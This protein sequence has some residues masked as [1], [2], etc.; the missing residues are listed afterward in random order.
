MVELSLL[1][2]ISLKFQP[3]DRI[4]Y[5]IRRKQLKIKSRVTV[6]L[7]Q[8]AMLLLLITLARNSRHAQTSVHTVS[9]Y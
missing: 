2:S 6:P 5:R 3:L 4:R 9:P 7:N 1:V 8:P